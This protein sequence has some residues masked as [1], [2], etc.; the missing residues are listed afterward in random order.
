MK[1]YLL[2]VI[3]INAFA[4]P[5]SY[6][7]T[8]GSNGVAKFCFPPE[9]S[10]YTIE[11][12]FQ[13]SGKLITLHVKNDSFLSV[14]RYSVNGSIDSTFGVLDSNIYNFSL[15]P[16]N[17][18]TNYYPL[19]LAVQSDD[20]IIISGLSQSS[21]GNNYW[22][23]RL[24]PDGVLDS[25]FDNDGYL[26]LSFGTIQDRGK[27]VAIQNDGKIILAG[28]SGNLGQN[29][30][31]ARLNTNGTLD[32]S[33]GING[34]VQTTFFG[35]L[36]DVNSIA[37]QNDGKIILAGWI[38]NVPY[39]YDYAL[40]RY[41]SD[42]SIDTTFG[43]NG[44]VVTTVS[45]L[46]SDR[47]TKLIIQNDGK[48]I[49]GGYISS[50]SKFAIV[51]Y[52]SDGIIDSTFGVNG[53]VITSEASGDNCSII[54]Q[55]DGKIIVAGGQD[56][57]IFTYQRYLNN[58]Q[59]DIDFPVNGFYSGI[60]LYGYASTVLIQPDNKIVI[61]GFLYSSDGSQF[62]SGVIRLNP[63]TLSINEFNA[64]EVVVYP[65]PAN[66]FIGFDNSVNQFTKATFFNYLGQEVALQSLNSSSEEQIDIS[67]FANGVYLLKL[68]NDT[69]NTTVKVV[70]K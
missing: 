21:L 56:T 38:N 49:A 33:F 47:I 44:K 10:G 65:N 67:S 46:Y 53:I 11:A 61:F 51:R 60:G 37:V 64:N 52:Q 29:F 24:M 45:S 35:S 8:F 36:S 43:I 14:L 70:K 48:I 68:S 2:L 7:T 31:M 63:G 26:D 32:P 30:A 16:F 3:C 19:S 62:C 59:L 25:T 50:L 15:S 1:K 9:S 4:Q 18:N 23:I 69:S 28:K 12:A 27:C 40:I 6:D 13:S 39:E 66:N 41:N 57:G 5:G 55:V 34:K 17:S 42:G 54:Q 22:A 58:G 20:K